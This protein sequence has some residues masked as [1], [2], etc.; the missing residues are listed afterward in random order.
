MKQ[1][2]KNFIHSSYPNQARNK[3]YSNSKF[4]TI[5]L[6][7]NQS[8]K[9]LM[10]I[11]LLQSSQICSYNWELISLIFLCFFFSVPLSDNYHWYSTR[12]RMQSRLFSEHQL[13]NTGTLSRG[14]PVKLEWFHLFCLFYMAVLLIIN[15]KCISF[16][17][18][19]ATSSFVSH[20]IYL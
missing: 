19:M 4:R 13:S 1:I 2:T 14:R 17:R 5:S 3:G 15:Y 11:Y 18:Q 12:G 8:W 9:I 20:I 10:I 16:L 7:H 6:Y